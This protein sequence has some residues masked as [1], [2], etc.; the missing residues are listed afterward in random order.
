MYVFRK[1]LRYGVN[2]HKIRRAREDHRGYTVIFRYA[3]AFAV[4]LKKRRSITV[5]QV[6]PVNRDPV[7]N[8]FNDAI[9]LAAGSAA[10]YKKIHDIALFVFGLCLGRY[11]SQEEPG[12]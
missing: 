7:F 4:P 11:K 2:P 5:N 8:L 12:K 1:T 3:I 9:S 10:G 6:I